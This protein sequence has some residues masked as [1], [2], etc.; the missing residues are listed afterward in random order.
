MDTFKDRL[1]QNTQLGIFLSTLTWPGIMEMLA[2]TGYDFV[3]IDTEHGIY[4]Y[5][6]VQALSRSAAQ[7]GIHAII[8]VTGKEYALVA[9]ALDMGA[10]SIMMP[11]VETA[12][13]VENLVKW[14]K[15]P[16]LGKRGAGSSAIVL[17]SDK[18]QFIDE[19]SQNGL[20]VIQI[21]TKTG[22]ENLDEILN[23]PALD[24]VFIG[25]LDLSLSLGIPGEFQNPVLVQAIEQII[26]KSRAAGKIVGLLCSPEQ[27]PMYANLGATLIAI[28]LD[29]SLLHA[30][31]DRAITTAR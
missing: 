7:L 31:V 11:T 19:T 25:P 6:Q 3:V 28:G 27:A 18:R 1:K 4:S 5:E 9:R 29:V 22:L 2:K 17:S 23:N 8:R 24:G 15:Y 20:V 12:A 14:A 21:E 30:A 16:P 26:T 13:E 10:D